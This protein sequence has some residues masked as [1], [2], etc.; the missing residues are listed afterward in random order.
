LIEE[1]E[2]SNQTSKWGIRL[3][4]VFLVLAG[5]V[6]LVS[7]DR[8][9]FTEQDKAYYADANLVA[10]VRPGLAFKITAVT[11]AS[12]GTVKARFTI[13]DPKGLPL[14]RD[15]VYTPGAVSTSFIL[16][17][18]PAGQKQYVAYTTRTQTSPITGVS[19]VQAGTDSGGTYEKNDIGDYTY[20]FRTKLPA[21]Y[22]ATA[23]HTVGLYGNRNLTEFG[24]GTNLAATTYN[25]VP[26]G[27]AVPIDYEAEQGPT[28]SIRVQELF[29]LS[30]HPAIAG[31][32]VPLVIELLSPAHRPVQVTRDLPGFWRG[33]YADVKTEMRGRYPRHPWPDDPTTAP[34]TRRAK[35]R[36]Q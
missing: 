22:D 34:A 25:F 24:L 14:D 15:G 19:A 32:R 21:G 26:T 8:P 2:V 27:S 9:A 23:T 4:A 11:V 36:G 30:Q 3:A 13:T 35:P 10:F 31:G 18:I 33:S 29:G 16:A 28:V 5:A 20:T 7:A 6:Y 17:R 1:A 12:D